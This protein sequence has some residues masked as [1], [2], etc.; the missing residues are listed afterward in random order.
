[1][2]A[3]LPLAYHYGL[4]ES[5]IDADIAELVDASSRPI[6]VGQA[7]RYGPDSSREP[8]QAEMGAT[9]DVVMQIGREFDSVR[10]QS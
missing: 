9:S 2:D 4:T 5:N 1:M 6:D 10:C 7:N 8:P 3:D